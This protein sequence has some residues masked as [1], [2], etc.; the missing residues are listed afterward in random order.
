[1]K[2]RAL[3]LGPALCTAIACSG[4]DTVSDGVNSAKIEKASSQW[5]EP[6]PAEN[7]ERPEPDAGAPLDA[8]TDAE[9]DAAADAGELPDGALLDG[10]SDGATDGA[11]PDGALPDGAL[12]DGALLDGALL[13]G[14][15][16]I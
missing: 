4:E 13:D 9:L 12:L 1:M 15:V 8:E 2:V 3:L 10:A 5:E 6:G 14:A 7:P 16:Q 11:L